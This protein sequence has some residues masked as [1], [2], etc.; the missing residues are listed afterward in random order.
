LKATC[1]TEELEKA[2]NMLKPDT[3]KVLCLHYQHHRSLQEI[4]VL[5]SRSITVVRNH[6]NR[7]IYK[8]YRYFN[9]RVPLSK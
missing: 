9:P 5:I 1:S 8:L 4:T 3:R 7:G 6:H 2:L